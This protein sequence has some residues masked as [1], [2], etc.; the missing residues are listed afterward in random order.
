MDSP[1]S[2]AP[3]ITTVGRPSRGRGSFWISSESCSAT[4]F[5]RVGCVVGCVVVV[6]VC[7]CVCVLGVDPVQATRHVSST[8]GET[9]H[10]YHHH[11]HHHRHKTNLK[12]RALCLQGRP[13]IVAALPWRRVIHQK[14]GLGNQPV[15]V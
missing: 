12:G 7:V 1:A 6:S 5:G 2:P 11:H 15:M 3:A 10:H 14:V 8:K 4:C 9:Q 13:R